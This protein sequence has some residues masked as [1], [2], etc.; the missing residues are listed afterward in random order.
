MDTCEDYL[1]WLKEPR[2]KFLKPFEGECIKGNVTSIPFGD[3]RFDLVIAS[4]VLEHL[5]SYDKAK[6]AVVELLR[7]APDA[8]IT[9][10]NGHQF[11][12]TH[13]LEFNKEKLVSLLPDGAM[14]K[15]VEDR[16]PTSLVL[17]VRRPSDL[18]ELEVTDNVRSVVYQH[19]TIKS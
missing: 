7:V 17:L 11:D 12:P 14:Y 3:D 2:I 9:V 13:H 6:G 4:E 19:P 5:D 1:K 10:P 18:C 8:L 15:F 16:K